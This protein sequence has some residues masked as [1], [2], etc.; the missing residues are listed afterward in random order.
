MFQ[1][2]AG[3]FA[4][5]EILPHIVTMDREGVFDHDAAENNY[6]LR[7]LWASKSMN[8]TGEVEELI[9]SGDS[10]HRGVLSCR[11]FRRRGD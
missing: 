2:M 5:N 8:L 3:E 1:S 4:A 9:L 11:C 10:G 6:S 7:A